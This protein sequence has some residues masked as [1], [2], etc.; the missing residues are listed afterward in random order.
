MI[1]FLMYTHN[2]DSIIIFGEILYL[3]THFLIDR[4]TP[5]GEICIERV[6]NKRSSNPRR[7][8]CS[9]DNEDTVT[10]NHLHVLCKS[11]TSHCQEL[12]MSRI[13]A[14]TSIQMNMTM[15]M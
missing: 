14:C 4:S 5:V 7:G 12:E 9:S 3:M 1:F 8:E 11:K 15:Q 13:N 2:F 6:K 10:T